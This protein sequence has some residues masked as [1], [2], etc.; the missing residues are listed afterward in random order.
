MDISPNGRL[1]VVG[2]H[3]GA[4]RVG[5]ARTDSPE[6]VRLLKGHVGDILS[7][8]SVSQSRFHPVDCY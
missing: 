8:H 6:D 7:C 4:L 1:Y 3:D 5:N 2:G